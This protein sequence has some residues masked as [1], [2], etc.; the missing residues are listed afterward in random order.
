MS[1]KIIK[2]ATPISEENIKALRA[3]DK[4]FLSGKVFTAR[5]AAHKRLIALIKKHKKLP[6]DI[7]GQIIFYAGPTPAKPGEEIGAVGP[8]T[9][10]RMDELTIPLLRL[11]LRGMIGKGQRSSEVKKGLAKYKAVYFVAT[12]GTAALLKQKIKKAKIIA[13]S[14]LGAEAIR[15]LEVEDFPVIVANDTLGQDLFEK[16]QKLYRKS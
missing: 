12:G 9:A 7:E 3:G 8:T 4:V 11:G 10:G 1:E 6:M 2:L 5:D 16:G 15:E 14:D 13:Y